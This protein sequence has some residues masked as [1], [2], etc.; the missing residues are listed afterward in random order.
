MFVDIILSTNILCI[1][2]NVFN[3]ISMFYTGFTYI[4]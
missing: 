1:N 4:R 2:F 3:N